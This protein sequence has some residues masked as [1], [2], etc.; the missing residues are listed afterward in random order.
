VAQAAL[1]DRLLTESVAALIEAGL[2]SLD[3]VAVDGMRIRAAAGAGSFR[4]K[5]RLERLLKEARAL[6]AR[7][8]REIDDDP[9]AGERRRRAAERRAAAERLAR[10]EAARR[11]LE[12]LEAERAR[13]AGKHKGEAAKK[14]EPRASTTD[15]EARVMKM[16]DGG[17]RPAYNAEIASDPATQ[18]VLAV[19]LDTTGSDHGWIG[20]MLGRLK[21]RFGRAPEEVLADGG[22]SSKDDIEAA[23][24]AGIA[25]YLRPTR[26]KHRTDP[27]APRAKDG[28]GLAAWRARMASEHGRAVYRERGLCERIHATMRH[29]GLNRL[30]VRG[31]AK[32]RA[33][34]LWHALAHNLQCWIRLRAAAAVA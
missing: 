27:F 17:F 5:G 24:A 21:D 14:A 16:A 33:V 29:H 10:V 1:L 8:R 15:P 2:V 34:V 20:P 23:A 19:D 31:A 4:R 13:R 32:A 26:S 9:A 6:V 25:V 18:V 22:F 28:P 12:A 30:T 3:R 7:L 11:R